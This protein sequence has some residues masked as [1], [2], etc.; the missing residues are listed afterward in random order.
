[1][2]PGVVCQPLSKFSMLI[3][4]VSYAMFFIAFFPLMEGG[5]TRFLCFW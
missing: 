1:M 4:G 5:Q 2:K 3:F